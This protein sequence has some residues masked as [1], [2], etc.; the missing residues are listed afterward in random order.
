M[1]RTIYNPPQIMWHL[2]A[3]DKNTDLCE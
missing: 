3:S 1:R 2:A